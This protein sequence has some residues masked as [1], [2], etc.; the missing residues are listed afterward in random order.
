MSL[1]SVER[2]ATFAQ[3]VVDPG[4][5]NIPKPEASGAQIEEVVKFVFGLIAVIAVIII[6]IAGISYITSTGDPQ[7]TARAKDTIVYAVI[8]LVVALLANIIVA[9]TIGRV[10]G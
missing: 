10:F 9:F 4:S 5:V 3:T 2:L 6:I 1:H 7:K 8:G